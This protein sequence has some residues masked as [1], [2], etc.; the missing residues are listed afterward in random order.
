M[1]KLVISLC[2]YVTSVNKALA[3]HH[4]FWTIL[5]CNNK[6]LYYTEDSE[7]LHQLSTFISGV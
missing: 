3:V 5:A 6:V 7:L 4:K 1:E 2:H